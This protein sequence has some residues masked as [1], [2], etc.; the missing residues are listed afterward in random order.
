MSIINLC[1]GQVGTSTVASVSDLIMGNGLCGPVPCRV[2][3]DEAV[4]YTSPSIE[5]DDIYGAVNKSITIQSTINDT[6]T[7]ESVRDDSI[8]INRR[9]SVRGGNVCVLPQA[10]LSTRSVAR[11]C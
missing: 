2:E 11:F 3:H 8:A 9:P 7:V 6:I 10:S 4:G 5:L 1:V